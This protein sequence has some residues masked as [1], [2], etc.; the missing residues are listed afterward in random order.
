[1]A[2]GPLVVISLN[3]NMG[4]VKFQNATLYFTSKLFYPLPNFYLN[5]PHKSTDLDCQNFI[6]TVSDKSLST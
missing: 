1:M 6:F 4:V 5:G 3:L 2:H